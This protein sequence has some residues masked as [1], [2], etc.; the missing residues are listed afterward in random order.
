MLETVSWSLSFSVNTWILSPD[1][2]AGGQLPQPPVGESI[3][4]RNAGGYQGIRTSGTDPVLGWPSDP[5]STAGRLLGG[6]PVLQRSQPPRWEG[7][8]GERLLR[9]HCQQ[10]GVLPQRQEDVGASLGFWTN[11]STLVLVWP[12]AN[13]SL[14]LG[15]SFPI[16]KEKGTAL[17]GSVRANCYLSLSAMGTCDPRMWCQQ[18][19]TTF[20]F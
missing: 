8:T 3:R 6:E 10:P 4:A 5:I 11:V 16:C 18:P 17:A 19:S 12:N 20:S 14:Q 7:V 9:C 15:A 13:P 1:P 2:A